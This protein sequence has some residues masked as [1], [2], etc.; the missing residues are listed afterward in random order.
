METP[1]GSQTFVLRQ[2]DGKKDV[3][4]AVMMRDCEDPEI[5]HTLYADGRVEHHRC[6]YVVSGDEGYDRTVVTELKEAPTKRL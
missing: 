6:H 5:C 2:A 4:L 3:Q 1:I